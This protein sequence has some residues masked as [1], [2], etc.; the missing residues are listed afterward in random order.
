MEANRKTAS[1]FLKTKSV[2]LAVTVLLL[3]M[4]G[5]T[6]TWALAAG[7]YLVTVRP[8][9]T[10]P[11]TGKVD[12]PG[13][14]EA[15]GQGMTE[16]MCGSTGLLEIDA[17]GTMYLTVR[18]YLSQFIRD[19]TFEERTGGSYISRN[20]QEMQTKAP[21][22]GASDI[23]DKY[24]YTDY[25][26]PVS[27]IDSVFRGNA[28]IEAMGRSVVFFFTA[29]NPV[30]GSGDFVVSTQNTQ[31]AKPQTAQTQEIRPQETRV[32][33]NRVAEELYEPEGTTQSRT[34]RTTE[35]NTSGASSS[36][37][38]G[39]FI[40]GSGDVDD[41]VTG[42]PSKP[43]ANGT[44]TGARTT[45]TAET[46]AAYTIDPETG[47]PVRVTENTQSNEAGSKNSS[48]GTRESYHLKTKYDLSRVSLSQ[49][50]K[51]TE[52]MLEEATGIT[53]MT[54]PAE[55]QASAASFTSENGEKNPNKTIMMVLLGI[56]AVLIARFGFALAGQRSRRLAAIKNS[57]ERQMEQDPEFQAALE[58]LDIQYQEAAARLE[59]EYMEKQQNMT[60]AA[61]EEEQ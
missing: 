58:K 45:G 50:R 54:G 49:A 60:T 30:S 8:S 47:M 2:I 59:R 26:I 32:V 38:D 53:G 61:A 34:E 29:S 23:S 40:N 22:D 19:V 10:D 5:T 25:R 7:S 43:S 15:I 35:H 52:P 24:G 36:V 12:D 27:S 46:A 41:P 51:L 28:Y 1:C 3:T 14:N 11:E 48:S 39:R 18:Y 4:A 13:N 9:Y 55:Y 44:T 17:S 33:D 21:I 42:L 31:S 57:P 37:E 6:Q 56:S 16:R 20:Y